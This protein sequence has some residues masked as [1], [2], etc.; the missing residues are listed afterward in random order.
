MPRTSQIHLPRALRADP[1][2]YPRES[3][4]RVP[5]PSRDDSSGSCPPVRV[6]RRSFPGKESRKWD[7]TRSRAYPAVPA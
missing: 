5:W 2:G 1:Q 6:Q 4:A 7:R 3:I